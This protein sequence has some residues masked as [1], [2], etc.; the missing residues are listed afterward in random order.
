MEERKQ[1]EQWWESCSRRPRQFGII[2]GGVLG[3]WGGLIFSF[4]VAGSVRRSRSKVET[5]AVTTIG[6]NFDLLVMSL[7]PNISF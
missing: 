2:F 7:F 6:W 3:G 4:G 5:T 1:A